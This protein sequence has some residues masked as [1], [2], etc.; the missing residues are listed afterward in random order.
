MQIT[1]AASGETTPPGGGTRYTYSLA[2]NITDLLRGWLELTGEFGTENRGRGFEQFALSP[3]NPVV[4]NPGNYDEAWWD[5]YDVDAIGTVSL[6]FKSGDEE[7]T[8][9][10]FLGNG[11]SVYDMTD[12][13]ALKMLDGLTLDGIVELLNGEFAQNAEEVGFT[14]AEITMQGWPWIEAGDALRITAEDGT[15]VNTYALR[16]ELSGIQHLMSDIISEGGEIVGE[17]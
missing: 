9:S 15:V 12:N 3:N 1:V 10:V 17:V 8:A 5:E 13:E 4:I 11:S 7:V 6:T 16:V 2:Y 14:P